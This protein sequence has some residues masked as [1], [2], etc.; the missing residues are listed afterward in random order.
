MTID[1]RHTNKSPELEAFE[2]VDFEWT[3]Q[4]KSVWLDSPYHVDDFHEDAVAAIL[5]AFQEGR[6]ELADGQIGKV[7]VGTAGSGKTHLVG[8]LRHKAWAQGGWFVLLEFAGIKDFWT[9]TALC[10]VTSLNQVMPS[11]QTQYQALLSR[12]V[13]TD[14]FDPR[15]ATLLARLIEKEHIAL[16]IDRETVRGFIQAFLVALDRIYAG[17]LPYPDVVRACL[18]LILGDWDARNIA[19]AWLQGLDLYEEDKRALGFGRD[20]P[21][22][23]SL[24]RGMSWLMSL[25]GPTLIAVDQIDAIIAEAHLRSSASRDG[26]SAD[27]AALSIIES[28]A[29]GLMELHDIKHRAMIVL[30]CLDKSWRVLDH[31]SPTLR[32]RFDTPMVLPMLQQAGDARALVEA[33]LARAYAEV[34]FTPPYSSWPFAPEAFATAVGLSPREL[35][36]ACNDHRILCLASGRIDEV[37]TFGGAIPP[38]DKQWPDLDALLAAEKRKVDVARILAS[39]AD[40]KAL[41]DVITKALDL[42][43]MQTR[44]PDDVDLSSNPDTGKQAPLHGRLTFTY[45]KEGDRERH[46][47]FRALSHGHPTAFMSRLKAAMTASGIDRKLPF[48]HLFILRRDALPSGPK[49]ATLVDEFRAAGGVFIAPSEEDLQTIVALHN[50]REA[51]HNGF[52]A[53]LQQR[54]PLC[55]TALFHS[56][57]LCGE[58]DLETAEGE[59]GG[60]T[61]GP[62]VVPEPP[63]KPEPRSERRI[64][65]G[66][67]IEGGGLGGV[68]SIEARYLPKHT[69]IV[70]GS[71]SGKTVLLRR[72]VEEAALLGIP[73]IVLDTNNDLVLLGEP[74]PAR[75]ATFTD[76]DQSKAESYKSNIEVVVWTP[77]IS[78]GRPLR[79]AVLPD[80]SALGDNQ[81]EREQAVQMALATLKPF[82]GTNTTT[83]AGKLKAGVLAGALAE[84]A[85]R[86]GKSLDELVRFLCDLPDQVTQIKDAPK[87]ASGVADQLLAAIALNPLLSAQ[88]TPLDPQELFGDEN[89][90]KTRISVINFSGLPSEESRQSFVNQLQMA[91]FTFV[92][93]QPSARGRLY[94]LDEAQNFAPAQKS[95]PCKESTVSLVA[96][97][98]KYGLGMIFATQTPKGIDNKIISNCT[99]HFYGKMNAPATIE[100]TQD[101]VAAK[102]GHA[103]DIAKL[104]TGVFYFATE[105]TPKPVKLRT[106]LCL[107]HHPQ[108][109]LGPDEVLA[110]ARS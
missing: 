3:R 8:T 70:A 67:R 86:G 106:P 98:R 83:G 45:H 2:A 6:K 72:I 16:Q 4:L 95:T 93:K 91:L 9:S 73:A 94:V 81:D 25:A 50:L 19:Y 96:Q 99:T 85:R 79:L 31:Q 11:G 74:W 64:P 43:V 33:R 78:A 7:V 35:L 20:Q 34:R 82:L 88:G 65:V 28:L 27:A 62:V 44:V 100:A 55:D 49:T 68:E 41:R 46:Y 76:E 24:V 39:D 17:V 80:F 42:Y 1:T 21:T 13:T 56:V 15:I 110:R 109:P 54:K 36:R 58:S 52:L 48:R 32:G 104:S 87:L 71:G 60:A 105:G 40:D 29:G 84:F 26:E 38:P 5:S 14:G 69:A 89:G 10:F 102:G 107:S 53:W 77:G 90:E 22:P 51:K 103:D 12:L 61:G 59:T 101:L 108:N 37:C 47:C 92:K 75:P 18:L 66:R 97:A 23:I 57:G 30:S 63:A